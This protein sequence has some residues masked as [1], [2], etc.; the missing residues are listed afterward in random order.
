M[1]Y[2]LAFDAPAGGIPYIHHSIAKRKATKASTPTTATI[3]SARR[4]VGGLL[5]GQLQR[6]C[7]QHMH[8]GLREASA[9]VPRGYGLA[10]AQPSKGVR[11]KGVQMYRKHPTPRV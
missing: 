10:Y 5:M 3:L 9:R 11:C 8:G 2:V 7:E 6:P 4:G 1:G